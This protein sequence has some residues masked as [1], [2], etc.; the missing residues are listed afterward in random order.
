MNEERS[1]RRRRFEDELSSVRRHDG[2]IGRERRW[3]FGGAAAMLGGA[4]TALAAFLV[5]LSLA[6]TRDVLSMVVLAGF[7]LCVTVAGAAVFLR[8]SLTRVLRLVLLRVLYEEPE[9]DG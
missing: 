7:G 3:T 4:A 8:N 5:S 9:R 1:D 2:V 6:D